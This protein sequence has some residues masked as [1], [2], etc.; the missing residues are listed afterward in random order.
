MTAPVNRVNPA[1]EREFVENVR[2]VAADHRIAGVVLQVTGGPAFGVDVAAAFNG[3]DFTLLLV[4]IAIVAVLLIFTYRSPFLR[5]I[6]L[7]STRGRKTRE[8][9]LSGR[10]DRLPA[11]RG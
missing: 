5:V 6:P 1:A 11:R 7:I 10:R 4:T 9:G 3:A 2:S 8:V